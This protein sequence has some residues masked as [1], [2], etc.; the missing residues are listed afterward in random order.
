[1]PSI[2]V[3]EADIRQW[4]A[5]AAVL[6]KKLAEMREDIRAARQLMRLRAQ[7][8]APSA[9]M[10]TFGT[11]NLMGAIAQL[12]SEAAEP[13]TKAEL[14]AKLEKLGFPKKRLNSNYFYVAIMKQREKNKI[15]VLPNGSIWR[16]A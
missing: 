10:N 13:I 1:M 2:T 4:E 9:P 11:E 6:E 12:A 5:D 3:S 8:Q 14:K 16:P 7:Q 15:S